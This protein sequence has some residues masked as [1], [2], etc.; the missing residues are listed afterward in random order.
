M[1][2]Y[3][4]A[5]IGHVFDKIHKY[6][7]HPFNLL[8]ILILL[9]WIV[10]N[11]KNC[12]CVVKLLVCNLKESLLHRKKLQK[13]SIIWRTIQ[14]DEN[15]IQK[16]ENTIQKNENT[17]QKSL[18]TIQKE[19]LEFLKNNPNSTLVEVIDSVPNLSEGGL[20]F[21][22]MKLK[23]LGLLKREGGRKSGIWVVVDNK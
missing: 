10:L 11:L 23:K 7:Y 3:C 13:R 14:K 1:L 19:V 6:L 21:I 2:F 20:K 4:S 18:T 9:L 5:L 15:T 16:N 17:I 8:N 22:I 12:V